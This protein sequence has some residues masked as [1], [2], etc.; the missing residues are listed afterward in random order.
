MERIELHK[1]YANK[2]CLK[3]KRRLI[4]NNSNEYIKN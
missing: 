4:N 1:K 3:Y 2:I